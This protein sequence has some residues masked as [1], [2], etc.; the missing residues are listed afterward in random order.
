MTVQ[1]CAAKH[2]QDVIRFFLH[3]PRLAAKPAGQRALWRILHRLSVQIRTLQAARAHPTS[4]YDEA[5]EAI[6]ATFGVYADQAMRVSDC[7]TGGTYS[8]SSANGQY[9]GIFQMGDNERATYGHGPSWLEQAQAAYRY[10]VASGRDWS[11]W[12]CKP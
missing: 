5:R 4:N 6:Y 2:D 11:P 9:L 1:A 3:H 10:F 12:E 7:E 8:P